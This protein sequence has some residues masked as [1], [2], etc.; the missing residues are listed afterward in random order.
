MISINSK[1][2]WISH[3]S[4]FLRCRFLERSRQQRDETNDADLFATKKRKRVTILHPPVTVATQLLPKSDNLFGISISSVEIATTR[5]L[6]V[7]NWLEIN[8]VKWTMWC[9]FRMPSFCQSDSSKTFIKTRVP[10][11]A[12]AT[13]SLQSTMPLCTSFALTRQ[14]IAPP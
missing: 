3:V 10:K 6:S 9:T 1:R 7:R 12:F 13:R 4:V 8:V 5:I 11:H 2:E 14:N